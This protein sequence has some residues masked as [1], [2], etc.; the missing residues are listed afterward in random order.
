MMKECVEMI[1]EAAMNARF[2]AR[3]TA[4]RHQQNDCAS[5]VQ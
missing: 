4:L 1:R 2:K 3:S 5:G